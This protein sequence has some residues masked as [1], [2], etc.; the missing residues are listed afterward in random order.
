LTFQAAHDDLTKL[1][2]RKEFERNLASAIET[3]KATSAQHVL[4]Y[5]D[6][7]QFKIVNN[8]SGHTAGDEMLK[9]VG[10]RLVE[11][12]KDVPAKVARLGGDEFGVLITDIAT[13]PS[14]DIAERLLKLVRE[15]RFDWEDRHYSLSVSIGVVFIDEGTLDA[16]AAMRSADEACYAAKDAGRNRVQEYELGD[17]RMMRR[18][19]VMEW[20]TQLDKAVDD[21][22]LILNCQRIAPVPVASNGTGSHYEI[23]LTMRDELG[24]LMPPSEFILAAE[25]YN[26]VTMVDRWVVENVLKW[27]AD[28]R[29][30]L[31]NFG[32]FAI[33]VSGHSVNDESFADFVLEQFSRMQAPTSKVCF[34]ITETAA[35]A[36]LDNARD[37]MNRMK[38]IGCR[39]SL[40]DFGTGLSSYSYL[41]NL[42]VDY[43][44]IDGVFVKDLNNNPSDYAVV[45]SI[46]EIGHYLGKKTIAEF[47][48]NDAILGQLREI[49]VD[50]AQG[51]GIEKPGLLSNLRLN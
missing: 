31:D 28:H 4:F 10:Q 1:L 51:Y 3:A 44:K 23:L 22:R 42:P 5:L 13:E 40:D 27:M 14:R 16:D 12:L 35:I 38:I 29:S 20:V 21:G 24:D 41:R 15:Q 49:G 9:M 48:E 43:V 17:A 7:D 19:G 8:S 6:L 46:N 33:N 39:F 45:R 18:R 47:V 34:E 30:A 50:Y 25:T 32:G 36:N 11:G 37:F 2:N 26:R